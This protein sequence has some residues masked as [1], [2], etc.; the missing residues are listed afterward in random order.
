MRYNNCGAS[1]FVYFWWYD[2]V[3]HEV[4]HLY[5]THLLS[6][7]HWMI[8]QETLYLVHLMMLPSCC[9]FLLFGYPYLPCIPPFINLMNIIDVPLLLLTKFVQF[10]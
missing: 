8:N 5:L 3:F 6:I 10:I 1:L 4:W 2:M 7:F 9:S